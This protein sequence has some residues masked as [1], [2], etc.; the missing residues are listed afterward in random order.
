MKRTFHGHAIQI[1]GSIFDN[2]T[3]ADAESAHVLV[4]NLTRKLISRN[5][6]IV[7][8]VDEEPILRL[9]N[10]PLSRVFYW[11][12]LEAVSDVASERR[13]C[14]D[15]EVLAHVVCSGQSLRRI[16]A[17][18]M[19]LWK[20]LLRSGA[21][22]LYTIPAEWTS[23][24]LVREKQESLSDALVVLGGHQGVEQLVSMYQRHGKLVLPLDVPL[25]S[26]AG[27][28]CSAAIRY[29]KKALDEPREFIPNADSSNASE[30][31]ALSCDGWAGKPSKHADSIVAFLE[32]LV[33]PKVF[34]VRLMNEKAE[35]FQS[36]D[37]FIEEVVLPV[38][39]SRGY[40]V[41]QIGR[42][43]TSSQFLNTEIIKGLN[44]SSI[45]IADMTG[46]RLNCYFELG[47]GFGIGRKVLVTAIEGTKMPFDTD[48][49]PCL[50][51]SKNAG[52]KSLRH[53]L[54]DFW[55]KN[56]DRTPMTM[57]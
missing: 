12:I 15:S 7:T 41:H 18:R 50:F 32:R 54:N 42:G 57:I 43:R 48:K 16:P 19:P 56:V 3:L 53:A 20:E 1:A 49:I 52:L 27:R 21:V 10:P 30:I 23:S 47:Y 4:R 44:E 40:T 38:A 2:A 8:M 55:S 31:A 25:G 14:H 29:H 11:D 28:E 17:K 36:V 46:S 24:Y 51:W 9:G 37:W 22:S 35:D 39:K 34:C 26:S 45:V 6:T 5:A 33:V 13:C